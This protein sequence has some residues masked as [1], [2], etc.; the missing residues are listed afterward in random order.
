MTQQPR[1]DNESFEEALA[2]ALPV[3]FHRV[4]GRYRDRQLAEEVT[5]DCLAAA[6]QRWARDPAYFLTHDLAQWSSRRAGWKALD[7]LRQR[8]R[9]RPLEEGAPD[10]AADPAHQRRR[11]RD[12]RLVLACLERLP[13]PERRV[14]LAHHFDN[15][16]DQEVGSALFGEQGTP[17]ARGLRVWRLRQRAY[18]RLRALLEKAGVE[19]ADWGGQAV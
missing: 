4:A 10:R 1:P 3:V 7:R 12:Q 16:T 6:W 14:L 15:Q 9:A 18:G 11:E 8:T 19:A 2:R 5:S 17:Q 13:E